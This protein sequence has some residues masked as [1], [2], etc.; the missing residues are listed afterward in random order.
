MWRLVP[1]V[2]RIGAGLAGLL[3][4]YAGT[5]LYED[6]Q[7]KIQNKLEEWWVRLRDKEN[8]AI[9]RHAAFMREVARLATQGF[10]RLLGDKIFSFRALCVSACYS[11]VSIILFGAV[12]FGLKSVRDWIGVL[13]LTI[14]VLGA[15]IL[16]AIGS[17]PALVRKRRFAIT[18]ILGTVLETFLL[19]LDWVGS[20]SAAIF[21]VFVALAGGLY[22]TGV[23]LTVCV[24]FG[25]VSD[26]LFIAVTRWLLRWCGD[27]TR[28]ERIGALICTNCALAV[29]LVKGPARLLPALDP[30]I[31]MVNSIDI[32]VSITFIMLALA[33]LIHRLLWPVTER[34]IYA[35][36]GLGIARRRKLFGTIGIALVGSAGVNLHELSKKIIEILVG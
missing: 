22:L 18:I 26:V 32:L 31:Y 12:V 8:P 7:G 34:A 35:L 4:L 25:F 29:G 23:F 20:G 24:C 27:M 11:L 30:W 17:L 15:A 1:V 28:P 2:V 10:N 16:L 14:L 36:Q 13:D 6:E 33:L 21:L 5:F 3:L 19:V 9:S